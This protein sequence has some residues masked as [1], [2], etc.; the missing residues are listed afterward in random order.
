MSSVFKIL[1][2]SQKSI[3]VLLYCHKAKCMVGFGHNK[4]VRT[5][6]FEKLLFCNYRNIYMFMQPI[7]SW[8]VFISKH[9]FT[10]IVIDSDNKFGWKVGNEKIRQV[11][12]YTSY[13]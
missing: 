8:I 3:N 6:V 9:S 11:Y 2:S 4:N 10:L 13:I 7:I 5:I 12:F 1:F